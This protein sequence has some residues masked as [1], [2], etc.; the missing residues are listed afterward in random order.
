[1]A[2]LATKKLHKTISCS[3][4]AHH[5]VKMMQIPSSANKKWADCPFLPSLYFLPFGHRAH[6]A[7]SQTTHQ[8]S[9]SNIKEGPQRWVLPEASLNLIFSSYSIQSGVNLLPIVLIN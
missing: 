5:D 4:F 7:F 2:G 1:M 3:Y 9:R 6:N 8:S